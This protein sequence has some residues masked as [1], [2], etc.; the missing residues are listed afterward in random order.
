MSTGKTYEASPGPV[1]WDGLI[2]NTP[3]V[4]L[5]RLLPESSFS[6]YAKLEMFNLGGSMKDRSSLG[7]LKE[8]LAKGLIRPG[9]TV[10]ESSSG[11]MGIGLAQ[12]CKRHNLRFICVVDERINEQNLKLLR[13]LGATINMVQPSEGK[14]LLEARLQRVQELLIIHPGSYW[15]NQYTNPANPAAYDTLMHEVDDA[16][17]GKVDALFCATGTCGTI[18]GCSDYIKKHKM[19]TKII[20]VDS[21]GSVIFGGRPKPRL[22]PGHGA[23]IRPP[24]FRSDMA[25]EVIHVS[26]QDCVSGCRYL[27]DTES[28]LA[29]GSSGAIITAL[30]R[31]ASQIPAGANVVL[32]LGDRGER[33][34]DTVYNDAWVRTHFE[35]SLLKQEQEAAHV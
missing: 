5:T 33:Y 10:I 26:D 15:P 32:I 4:R 13:A 31:T 6:I 8:G 20:A 12:A 34:V 2:G 16:L 27:R 17:G 1:E 23:A 9:G 11:N 25:D 14:S 18:R 29:G 30:R 22:I 3:L 35:N 7:M 21:D 19:A 24:L 28:I